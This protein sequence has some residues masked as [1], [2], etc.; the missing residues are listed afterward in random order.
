LNSFLNVSLTVGDCFFFV[1][2]AF[3]KMRE[4][5]FLSRFTKGDDTAT[6]KRGKPDEGGSAYLHPFTSPL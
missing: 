2:G 1:V 3:L 6:T 5:I 4:V